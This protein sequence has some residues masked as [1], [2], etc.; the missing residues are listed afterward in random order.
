METRKTLRKKS[1]IMLKLYHIKEQNLGY[2]GLGGGFFLGSESIHI[3]ENQ[4]GILQ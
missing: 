2:W 1:R 3:E 4:Y